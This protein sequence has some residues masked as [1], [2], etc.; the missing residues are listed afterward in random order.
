MPSVSDYTIEGTP[1]PWTVTGVDK[2]IV[3]SLSRIERSGSSLP[4]RFFLSFCPWGERNS[5]GGTPTEVQEIMDPRLRLVH[6][7]GCG[8]PYLVALFGGEGAS[9]RQR[10]AMEKLP[11]S[12]HFEAILHDGIVKLRYLDCTEDTWEDEE[13]FDPRQ[14]VDLLQTGELARF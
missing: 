4:S 8:R 9:D 3:G 7:T 6:F 10:I 5:L 1:P 2:F 12:E 14:L 11:W 13:D